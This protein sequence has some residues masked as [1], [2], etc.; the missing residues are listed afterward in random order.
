MDVA[1]VRDIGVRFSSPWFCM[2][3]CHL[4]VSDMAPVPNKGILVEVYLSWQKGLDLLRFIVQTLAQSY[5]HIPRIFDDSQIMRLRD[6]MWVS[7]ATLWGSG[8]SWVTLHRTGYGMSLQ[9]STGDV[10]WLVIGTQNS[11]AH[12]HDKYTPEVKIVS[13]NSSPWKGSS[14]NCLCEIE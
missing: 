11:W 10:G 8:K 6:N 7:V 5:L 3:L 13:C 9:V 4:V 2:I 14:S 12:C 1:E